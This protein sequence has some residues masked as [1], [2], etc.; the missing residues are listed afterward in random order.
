MVQAPEQA[1]SMSAVFAT[2]SVNFTYFLR[3]TFLYKFFAQ[4]LCA[5]NLGLKFFGRR[6]LAQKLLIKCW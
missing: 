3:A 2:A 5:Y 4:L 1:M 6:I